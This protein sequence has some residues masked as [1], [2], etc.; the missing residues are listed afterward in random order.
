NP[1]YAYQWQKDGVDIEGETNNTYTVLLADVGSVLTCSVTGSNSFGSN[2]AESEGVTVELGILVPEN[3][4]L[5]AISGTAQVG[6]TL[7]ASTG[8]W[9]N[10]PDSYTYQWKRAGVN[11]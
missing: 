3:T 2:T 7:T 10:E 8:T 6:E 1:T 11:I 4:V 5:P 9:I